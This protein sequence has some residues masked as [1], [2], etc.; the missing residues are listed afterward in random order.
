MTPGLPKISVITPSYNQGQFLEQTI[1]SVIGQN[2]PNL[3]YIILDGGSTDNSVEVIKKYEQHITY[4]HSKKD[5]GQGAAVNEGFAKATGD[6]LCWLN[7]DDLYMPGTLLKVGNFFKDTAAPTILFGNCLHFYENSSKTRGS[8]V[9]KEHNTR[10]LA[11]CDY[12]IQP[13]SFWNRATWEKNGPINEVFHFVFDWEW[14]IRAKRKGIAFQPI[15]D[16]LSLY[17]IHASHKSG[18]GGNKRSKELA[19]IYGLYSGEKNKR[20]FA[21]W[22][23]YRTKYK[24][25]HDVVY[26]SQR[27]DLVF[28][29]RIIH[30]L[31]FNSV[32]FTE[33]D[34][35]TRM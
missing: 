33:F 26:A 9:V 6:I 3:E 14:F 7:S 30:M 24:V 22:D 1:L 35:I 25:L 27:Y 20:A 11:L 23:K 32:S 18:T 5:N 4:W 2:Y 21:K 31:M 17:R 29:R 34:H 19:E 16:Y 10:E 13:S 15:P 28:I 8:D 12:V